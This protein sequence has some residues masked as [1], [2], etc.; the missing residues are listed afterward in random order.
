VSPLQLDYLSQVYYGKR[1]FAVRES[2]D[3]NEYDNSSGCHSAGLPQCI[4]VYRRIGAAGSS[5]KC[6]RHLSAVECS[7]GSRTRIR[8]C[9]ESAPRYSLEGD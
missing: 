3:E 6:S 7:V 9:H 5:A 4:V 8:N 2:T 1:Q